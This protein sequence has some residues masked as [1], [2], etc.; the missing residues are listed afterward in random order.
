VRTSDL[1]RL[2]EDGFVWIHG[3]ADDAIILGGFKIQPEQVRQ[4]LE[5]HPAV[6]EAAVAALPDARLGHVP[7][8]AVEVRPGLKP[9]SEEELVASCR[10]VLTPYEVPVHI[11]IVD[12]LPR[13]P[14]SKVSRVDLV[15]LV[16]ASLADD[17]AA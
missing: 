17:G 5:R 9:P 3:R 12:A 1:A 15:D 14:S 10:E 2:D 11:V 6:Q 13:T 16:R 8:A 4:A 7:V